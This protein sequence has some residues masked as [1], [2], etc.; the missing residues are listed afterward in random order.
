MIELTLTIPCDMTTSS[1]SMAL[2]MIRQRFSGTRF[3]LSVSVP[4]TYISELNRIKD[5]VERAKLDIIFMR[6]DRLKDY[7]WHLVAYNFYDYKPFAHFY[8]KGA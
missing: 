2:G 6:S 3:F 8:S 4:E 7:E 1:I 5:E